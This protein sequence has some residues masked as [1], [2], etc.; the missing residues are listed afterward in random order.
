MTA[1]VASKVKYP[2]F[3]VLRKSVTYWGALCQWLKR[4]I[5]DRGV[6]G[7]R[8]LL[9]AF[10][11]GTLAIPF[12]PLCPCLSEETLNAV[13]LFYLVSMPGDVKDPTQRVNV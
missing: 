12:T 10:R 4:S 13:G 7:V 11:F 2:T 3:R 8:I 5:W 9:A 6:L 1:I